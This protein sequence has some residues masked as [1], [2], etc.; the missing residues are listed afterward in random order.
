MKTPGVGE[1]NLNTPRHIGGP[2][3]KKVKNESRLKKENIDK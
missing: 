3:Y 1:Y 2:S